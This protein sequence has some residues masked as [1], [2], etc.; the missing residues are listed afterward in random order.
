MPQ[1]SHALWAGH[2]SSEEL[3]DAVVRHHDAEELIDHRG[4][5][6]QAAQIGEERGDAGGLYRDGRNL[7]ERADGAGERGAGGSKV[8]LVELY[9][10]GAIF[11]R[12]QV[13]LV[14]G[15]GR[16][17]EAGDVGE[18]TLDGEELGERA[19]VGRRLNYQG[20]ASQVEVI[21]RGAGGAGHGVGVGSG[22]H[23]RRDAVGVIQLAVRRDEGGGVGMGAQVLA[24]IGDDADAIDD[25]VEVEAE[26]GA[27]E[28]AG[29]GS[30]A[31]DGGGAGSGVDDVEAQGAAEGVELLVGRAEVH[32]DDVFAGPQTADDVHGENGGGPF[33]VEADEDGARVD[34]VNALS[35]GGS[36]E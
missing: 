18:V 32:A 31:D 16:D 10:G 21:E 7:I 23:V 19:V 17:I 30:A 14:A 22:D 26:A 2:R 15:G 36:R 20:A 4:D 12:G 33:G 1:R 6:G 35:G 8:D 5:G 9:A 25:G 3:V 29:D 24:R 28:V 11:A 13:A 34:G 27:G